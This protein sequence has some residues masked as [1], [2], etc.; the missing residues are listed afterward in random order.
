MTQIVPLDRYNWESC[1]NISLTPDQEQFLP[2]V[3]YSLA[4]ANF[5]NLHPYGIVYREK[6]VGFMMY[7]EFTGICWINRIMIDQEYQ[8]QGI[9][10]AAMRQLIEK[11]WSKR[12]CKEI[13]TS[14]SRHNYIV[15]QFFKS[16]GFV[17]GAEMEGEEIVATL[18]PKT[19]TSM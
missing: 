8:R 1:L 12:T 10:H 14:Y 18:N 7:G 6:M 17:G 13:R 15:D 5:E 16:L 3:L 11:L 9:G 19:P 4:Q 2:S